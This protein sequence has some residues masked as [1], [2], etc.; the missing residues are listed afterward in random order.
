MGEVAFKKKDYIQEWFEQCC[1]VKYNYVDYG[2]GVIEH[3][4]NI[5][6]HHSYVWEIDFVKIHDFKI[7]LPDGY[8]V[9]TVE[10]RDP[11]DNKVV[12]NMGITV[13][14]GKI[15]PYSWWWEEKF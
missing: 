1:E 12:I 6:N 5:I 2:F 14:N 9:L 3:G 15:D 10:D 11:D 8:H 13:R 4:N 7:D